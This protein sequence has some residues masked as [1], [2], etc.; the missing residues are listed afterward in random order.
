M[1]LLRGLVMLALVSNSRPFIWFNL[2]DPR[3]ADPEKIR[4]AAK[5]LTAL[6]GACD[7]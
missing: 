6:I 7:G 2:R 4:A 3:K 1:K 5:N